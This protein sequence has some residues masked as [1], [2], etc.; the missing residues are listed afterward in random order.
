M[1]QKANIQKYFKGGALVLYAGVIMVLGI[2]LFFGDQIAT[3]T[4]SNSGKPLEVSARSLNIAYALPVTSLEP[5][6]FDSVTRSRLLNVYEGLVRTDH[7]LKIEPALAVSWGLV[8]PTVWEFTLRPDVHFHNAALMTV[9]DV[10]LSLERARTFEGSQLKTLLN[11]VTDVRAMNDSTLRITTSVPDP[12]LLNKLA[13]TYVFP[14]SLKDFEQPMGTGPYAFVASGKGTLGKQIALKRFENYWGDKPFYA[15]VFLHTVLDRGARIDALKNGKVDLLANVPPAA[16]KDLASDKI[17]LKTIPSLEV[18]FVM[19]N[20]HDGPFVDKNLREAF[21]SSIEGKQFVDI[22]GGY[23]RA[24]KQFVSSGVFGFNP[25][26]KGFDYNLEHAKHLAANVV[27]DSPVTMDYADSNDVVPQYLQ[28]QLQVLGIQLT[29]NPLKGSEFEQKLQSGKSQ[30]YYLGWRSELGDA[31]D[32]LQ[33]IV[34]SKGEFNG[35]GYV[36]KTVDDLID[37]SQQ[38]LNIKIRL[39]SLQEAMKLIVQDDIA[40]VPLF[41]TQ[42]IFAFQNS[43]KFDPRV[44]GYIYASEIK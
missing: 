41:E 2:Q 37:K 5:T 19:L 44:D 20:L 42:T 17:V 27:K 28:E 25:N 23:A 3:F 7:N 30:M 24:V 43:I 13:V 29:L 26:V 32:F 9:D 1:A 38:D 11:S 40:G 18:S 15:Q 4:N 34:H 8:S 22:A 21:A 36:S 16:A 33:S 35:T 39:K 10:V 31:S 12:L 14:K 6:L